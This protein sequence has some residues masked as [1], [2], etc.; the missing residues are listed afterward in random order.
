VKTGDI[1]R[2]TINKITRLAHIR[3]QTFFTMMRQSGLMPQILKQL[4][5]K[6]IEKNTPIPC[7]IN[8]PQELRKG[9]FR[10]YPVFIGNE[11]VNYLKRYLKTR[12]NLTP[13]SLLFAAHTNAKKEINTKDVSKTFKLI[14][15]KLTITPIIYSTKEKKPSALRLYSLINFYKAN[16][17]VYLKQLNSNPLSESEEFCR[18]LYKEKAMPYLEI[19][20]PIT[21]EIRYNKKRLQKEFQKLNGENKIM[22]QTIA[23]DNEYISSIL[24]LIYNN[25]G[26]PETGENVKIGNE[27]VELWKETQEKQWKHL[28]W[29]GEDYVE[30][31]DIIEEFTKTLRRIKKPYDDLEAKQGLS[32]IKD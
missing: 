24:T 17:K 18:K 26:D 12:E 28:P 29:L 11:A 15:K 5:I 1:D 32:G 20:E 4:K 25:M 21:V 30:W 22:R 13:E 14:L 7:K 3:E 31:V 8:I 6:D 10:K 9:K 23:R 27:F 19:E 16:T 2:A